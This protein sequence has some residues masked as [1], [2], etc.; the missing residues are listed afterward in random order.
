[1][2][3]KNPI[4]LGLLTLHTPLTVARMNTNKL[5][6][7]QAWPETFR[8]GCFSHTNFVQ[9]SDLL[10]MLEERKTQIKRGLYLPLLQPPININTHMLTQTH[11]PPWPAA[12]HTAMHFINK[13]EIRFSMCVCMAR[14]TF[15]FS[16]H[17]KLHRPSV[18]LLAFSC[19]FYHFP[20]LKK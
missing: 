5:A 16:L 7:I 4:S 15:S 3:T 1:M 14:I 19:V 6:A 12:R 10:L 8:T 9:S 13:D 20:L 11:A 18:L 17:A 2:Q